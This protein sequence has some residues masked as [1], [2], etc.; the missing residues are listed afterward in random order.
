MDKLS[1]L[2]DLIRA[3]QEM[4]ESG[5]VDF[6]AGFNPET[7]VLDETTLF[8]N[9]LK[10]SF[11]NYVS[12]FNQMK[13]NPQSRIK[14]YSVSKTRADF[15]LF[16]NGFKIVFSMI[17][18]GRVSVSL[19]HVGSSFH[20]PGKT[21]DS[22]RTQEDLIEALQG[23]FGKLT[24]SYQGQPVNVEHMVKYYLSRFIRESVP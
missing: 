13:E 17:E 10:D 21:Q 7:Q 1:W 18:P 11:V 14:I 6:T 12:T 20:I 8:L 4:E 2:K 9:E 24:W 16:R 5:V 22:S 19:S 15:M 23:A 3:D